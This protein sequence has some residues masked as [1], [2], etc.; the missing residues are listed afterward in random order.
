MI[1]VPEL[2][3]AVA[4]SHPEVWRRDESSGGVVANAPAH[5]DFY[6]NP[7]G[8]D[9]ADAESLLNAATVLGTAPAGDF[10]LSAKVTVDFRSKF[11]AGVLL[12]WLDEK[13]W[14]K[15]CFEF[16]PAAEPMVVSVV[17]Q[18]VSDDANAFVVGDRSVWLRVSRIDH[19]YAYHASTDGQRWQFVRAFTLGDA[20]SEHAIG[21]EAQSPTGDGVVV[22][23]D[24]IRFT[25]RRL[26]ELR[27]GS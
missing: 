5:T 7:G 6:I 9:S 14:A 11:D 2:P 23:F 21:F 20:V 24:E 19:V 17:N 10:Q 18:G 4:P 22:T 3:F 27:D 25:D 26:M 16:S 8:V 15:L 1:E 12:L 13:N